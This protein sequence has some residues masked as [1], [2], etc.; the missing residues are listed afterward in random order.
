MGATV[1]DLTSRPVRGWLLVLVVLVGVIAPVLGTYTAVLFLEAHR[2]NLPVPSFAVWLFYGVRAAAYVFA[3]SVLYF[4]RYRLAPKVAVAV[5][6]IAGPI[7]LYFWQLTTKEFALP[8]LLKTCAP[9]L[10]WT[11]Y[12]IMSERVKST[13]V[14]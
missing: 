6:W 3:G 12:L 9:A 11:A 8:V 1:S 5:L 2:T 4:K 10:I 14:D 7:S 13:Y